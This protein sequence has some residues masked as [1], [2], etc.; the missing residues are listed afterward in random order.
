MSLRII[1]GVRRGAK[2]K[3]LDGSETRP[4]RD[5]I[6]EALFNI[7][8]EEIRGARVLDLFSGS[9]AVGLEAVSRGAVHA[10]LVDAHSGAVAV[11]RENVA[12]LRFEPITVVREG[13]SPDVLGS[14]RTPPGGY[15][16]V[17]LMPPYRSGLGAEAMAS[18]E[19]QS[20]LSDDA[21]VVL[22]LHRDENAALPEGWA[23]FDDRLYGITRLLF[24]RRVRK[25]QNGGS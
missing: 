11:A 7:L 3:T 10:T 14:L 5:R 20:R 2:L 6:R 22:E 24:L 16:M 4:L 19:F 18:A 12:H 21:L 8:R 9:G 25:N 1:A 15:S 13:R 17:F 23:A